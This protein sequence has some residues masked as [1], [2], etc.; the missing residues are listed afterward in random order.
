MR[1]AYRPAS[2]PSCRFHRQGAPCARPQLLVCVAALHAFKHESHARPAL[3][4]GSLSTRL[5]SATEDVMRCHLCIGTLSCHTHGANFSASMRALF[6]GSRCSART[7]KQQRTVLGICRKIAHAHAGGSTSNS[8]ARAPEAVQSSAN[9][10]PDPSTISAG[11][12]R[13][14]GGLLRCCAAVRVHV[15][16]VWRT[17]S[18]VSGPCVCPT[19]RN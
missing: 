1:M 8:K 17:E 6:G 13:Y 11:A 9:S 14:V 7:P 12:C 10:R 3:Q 18:Q 2:R 15:R 4:S 5:G 16:A 19:L